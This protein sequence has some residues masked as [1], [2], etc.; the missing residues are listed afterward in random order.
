MFI[1]DLTA[2]LPDQNGAQ[3]PLEFV[4]EFLDTSGF[5]EMKKLQWKAVTGVVVVA[6]ATLFSNKDVFLNQ[7]LLEKF[8]YV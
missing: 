4:R 6:A 8:W 2:P 3:P 5:Y 1:D 7:R